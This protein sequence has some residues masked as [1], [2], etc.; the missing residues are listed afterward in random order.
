MKKL[1]SLSLI[2]LALSLPCK[3]GEPV[4]H[5]LGIVACGGIATWGYIEGAKANPKQVKVFVNVAAVLFTLKTIGHAVHLA[6]GN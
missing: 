6:R 3:A 1:I 5:A 4:E 2:F